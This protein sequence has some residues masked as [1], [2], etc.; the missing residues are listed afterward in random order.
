MVYLA[1]LI[2]N[3]Q[4]LVPRYDSFILSLEGQMRWSV[5]HLGIAGDLA[6][7]DR[8][9]APLGDILHNLHLRMSTSIYE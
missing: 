1:N 4:K 8:E 7:L 3:S 6:V 9:D 5:L 2:G